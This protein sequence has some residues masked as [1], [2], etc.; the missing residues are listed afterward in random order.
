MR[1]GRLLLLTI[2]AILLSGCIE[3]ATPDMVQ[4]LIEQNLPQGVG[5][6]YVKLTDKNLELS[7]SP[8]AQQLTAENEGRFVKS[9]HDALLRTFGNDQIISVTYR[10]EN[11]TARTINGLSCKQETGCWNRFLNQPLGEPQMIDRNGKLTTFDELIDRSDTIVITNYEGE[12]YRVAEVLKGNASLVKKIIAIPDDS[13]RDFAG[14]GRYLLFLN[15][16]A[17]DAKP[18]QTSYAITGVWSG[19]FKL[20]GRPKGYGDDPVRKLAEEM[21]DQQ[22]INT[23]KKKT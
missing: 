4:P 19:K 6:Q 16:I 12:T 8:G 14:P 17:L 2:A 3:K 13:F 7:L 15:E 22:L 11:K 5:L 20:E 23:I 9:V 21:T 10:V 1:I 18:Q